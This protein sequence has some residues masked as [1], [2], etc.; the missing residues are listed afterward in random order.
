MRFVLVL[1]MLCLC[2]NAW[3]STT[4]DEQS[5]IAKWTGESICAMGV[6]RFYS[7][8]EVELRELFEGQTGMAYNDIPVEP[9]ETER[10]RITSQL[11]AYIASVCPTE[12]ENYRRR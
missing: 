8:S 10:L 11:T 1:A 2:P 6:D 7:I 12:L 9:T 4:R 5:I 3:S